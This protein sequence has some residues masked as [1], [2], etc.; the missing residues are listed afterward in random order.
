[1]SEKKNKVI[2]VDPDRC[3]GCHGCEMACSMQHFDLNSPL[4]SRVRIQEFREVNTF[5]PVVCQ[6]CADAACIKS[7]PMNARVRLDSGAVVT[8]EESC[9]GCKTCVYSCRF[10]ALF[11]NP[12]SGLPMSCDLC[13]GEENGPWCVEACKMQKALIFVDVSESSKMRSRDWAGMVK[14]DYTP[15]GANRDELDFESSGYGSADDD[16]S[17]REE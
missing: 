6:A 11:T 15:P 1:M 13:E 5:V 8:D 12:Q 10:G 3:T 7:C 2:I 4:Y 14:K 9:I 16:Q 17:T